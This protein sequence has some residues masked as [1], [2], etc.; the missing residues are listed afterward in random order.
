MSDNKINQ[1][2]EKLESLTQKQMDFFREINA[3]KEEIKSLKKNKEVT[4]S[5]YTSEE[6][7]RT[8]TSQVITEKPKESIITSSPSIKKHSIEP[9]IKKPVNDIFKFKGKSNLEK[10]IGENLLN[11]IG[12]AIT[13][14]GLAI[15]TKYSI[16]HNLISPTLRIILGYLFGTGLLLVGMKLRA[17]YENYSAVLVSGAMA[18]MYFIT[19]SAYS[20]FELI[21]QVAAFLIMVLF[22]IFTVIAAL[23]YNRQVIAHIGLV[24]AYAVPFLLSTE[25]GDVFTLFTYMSIINAGILVISFKKY[26]KPLYYVS[27]ALSWVIYFSWYFADYE[28]IQHFGI[29]F[30]FLTLF[31][32]SFYITFLAYKLR[33]KEKFNWVD[34]VLLLINS[35][36]FYGVGYALLANESKYEQILG[37]YTLI[38]AI[39]HFIIGSIIYKQKLADRNLFYFVIGLVLLFITIAIPVQLDG[40]WVTLLWVGQAALL[41]WIGKTKKVPAYEILS[42]PLMI[43][44]FFSLM[45]DWM[46]NYNLYQF[47]DDTD[48]MTTIF[49]ISFL[50]SLLFIAAFSFITYIQNSPKYVA[51]KPLSEVLKSI[52]NIAIPAILLLSVYY[53]F[54]V[55]ISYYWDKLYYASEIT[56]KQAGDQYSGSMYDNDLHRFKSIWTFNYTFVFLSILSLVNFRKIK[57][58]KLA[59]TTLSLNTFAVA[60]FLFA[61]IYTLGELRDSYVLQTNAQY[62]NVGFFNVGIRYIS[63]ASLAI[64]LFVSHL[65]IKKMFMQA[66]IHK[67]FDLILHVV[68]VT[69]ISN[70]LITWLSINESTSAYKTTLSIIWGVYALFLITLGI[71]QKKQYLRIAAISFFGLTLVKLFFYDLTELSTIQ[72]TIVFVSLGVLLLI[73]SFLYNKFKVNINEGKE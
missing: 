48:S 11:K 28:Y 33:T 12:I 57:N 70:E 39:I 45:Q 62:Y 4:Q 35:F 22:T 31:F 25:S 64:M 67:A 42:Y 71:I 15:G 50:S 8:H 53:A 10:F 19:Y 56:V 26:W 36:I 18:S 2:Q 47:S 17:K 61:G 3:L 69:A 46:F 16:D 58:T 59:I 41:Y 9:K 6:E 20:I 66:E 43:L 1:L 72:K 37:L 21:P 7:T 13:V 34:I 29:A 55:E 68:I 38:N 54:W 44:A 65:Y 60:V 5:P 51:E 24:G 63:F 40:N 23:S 73:I 30:S 32:A 27:F 14:I 52:T 49:N